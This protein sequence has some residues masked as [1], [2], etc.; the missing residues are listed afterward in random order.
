MHMM[1]CLS[2]NL[3]FLY[4]VKECVPIMFSK[5]SA[6]SHYMAQD[7]PNC[8]ILL[9]HTLCPKLSVQLY[10]MAKRETPSSFNTKFYIGKPPKFQFSFV[11]GQ[12]K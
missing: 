5:V 9:F 4:Y 12:S 6:S 7:V 1:L 11:V 3:G 2:E 8:T 10:K